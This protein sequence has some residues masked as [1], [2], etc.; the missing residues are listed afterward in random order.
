MKSM[1]LLDLQP[2]SLIYLG[3]IWILRE[4]FGFLH[5]FKP[6]NGDS[7]LIDAYMSSNRQ[8]KLTDAIDKNSEM[9]NKILRVL[10]RV[11][12]KLDV[13]GTHSVEVPPSRNDRM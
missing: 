12:T 13:G 2:E 7:K 8:D 3:V 10:E 1:N 6:G 4:V 9:I 5:K 11:E